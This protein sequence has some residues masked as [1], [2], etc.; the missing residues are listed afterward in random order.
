MG[1][2]IGMRHAAVARKPGCPKERLDL[3]LRRRIP[4]KTQK[5]IFS[6]ALLLVALVAV[7]GCKQEDRA[8]AAGRR[9]AGCDLWRADGAIDRDT[10]GDL[11]R[12]PGAVE[13]EDDQ[14]EHISI[15]GI[16][17][18]PSVGVK[19]VTPTESTT[20]HLVARGDGGRPMLRRT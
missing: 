3:F 9:G 5:S 17:D 13:L 12:R 8:L 10:D 11:G 15:D 1:A 16:G 20:Y 18:V 2:E 7:S 19:T 4:L 6:I 14:R